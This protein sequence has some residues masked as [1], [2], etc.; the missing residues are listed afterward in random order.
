[1]V[2]PI[3]LCVAAYASRGEFEAADER[4]TASPEIDLG[5]HWTW[6]RTWHSLG[7]LTVTRELIVHRTGDPDDS[8]GV[9]GIVRSERAL[10][11]L[12]AAAG[13]DRSLERL[14]RR[15]RQPEVLVHARH[16]PARVKASVAG[17]YAVVRLDALPPTPPRK[18]MV[19]CSCSMCRFP[20]WAH[21]ARIATQIVEL[22]DDPRYMDSHVSAARL[23]GV[24]GLLLEGLF[25]QPIDIGD[26]TGVVDGMKR[27]EQLE[28]A[29]VES[30]VVFVRAPR[31]SRL[32]NPAM[33]TL[34]L[35]S[36]GIGAVL[37]LGL[38]GPLEVAPGVGGGALM[39]QG[40]VAVDLRPGTAL[41]RESW[42]NWADDGFRLTGRIRD[43]LGCA[44]RA[45][46]CEGPW[47]VAHDVGITNRDGTRVLGTVHAGAIVA[48]VASDSGVPIWLDAGRRD[49]VIVGDAY[50]GALERAWFEPGGWW[51][52]ATTATRTIIALLMA[53]GIA[54]VTGVLLLYRTWR[55]MRRARVIGPAGSETI[56]LALPV[57]VCVGLIWSTVSVL[58]GAAHAGI[59]TIA[60]ATA[61]LHAAL[62]MAWWSLRIRVRRHCKGKS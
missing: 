52:G 39:Q 3:R 60:A 6:N 27:I 38:G 34:P 31:T 44:D 55:R 16:R 59:G 62:T 7:W 12:V 46:A 33:L 32:L 51:P 24:A 48:G 43:E 1:M 22:A 18:G 26:G 54:L 2:R 30:C 25:T 5:R 17:Y 8:Y 15:L 57:V 14:A 36:V 20:D 50:K 29:G 53:Q 47:V 56:L 35:L 40:H 58:G 11:K 19:A 9:L 61:A 21:V 4:R 45:E 42:P 28:E 13:A 23:D 41:E 10:R 37:T 49:V